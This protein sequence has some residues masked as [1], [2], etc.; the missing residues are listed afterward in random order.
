[1]T[2]IVC[3]TR[4][5]IITGTASGD[6]EGDICSV[7]AARIT[8]VNI[9]RAIYRRIVAAV[10]PVVTLLSSINVLIPTQ[11]EGAAR[12]T[13]GPQ[14]AGTNLAGMRSIRQCL[15]KTLCS[16]GTDIAFTALATVRTTGAERTAAE[17]AILLI[18]ELTCCETTIPIRTVS[19]ITLLS[20][21]NPGIAAA[22]RVF[23]AAEAVA[24]IPEESIPIVALFLSLQFAITA[25]R[26]HR[27]VC[28]TGGGIE[29]LAHPERTMV[30]AETA[31]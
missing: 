26:L 20:R 23:Q 22:R 2:I 8:L 16:I 1:M 3:H 28:C 10:P 14:C 29:N 7:T 30:I 12:N 18:F 4:T 5:E 11:T 25:L 9:R 19:V 17:H 13:L 24:P 6:A 31:P 21:L 15:R 27:A